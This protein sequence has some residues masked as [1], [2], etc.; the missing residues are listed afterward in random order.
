MDDST[1]EFH[2][3][4]ETQNTVERYVLDQLSEDEQ[5]RFE[6]HYAECGQCLD[7]VEAAQDLRAGLK[8]LA[9]GF[10]ADA[11][12][13]SATPSP[14]PETLDFPAPGT[15]RATTPRRWW[16]LAAAALFAL[17]T[18]PGLY[19]AQR[20][21]SLQERLAAVERPFALEPSARL[22][23]QRGGGDLAGGRETDV[24]FDPAASWLT[25]ELDLGDVNER[26][27]E[28][29]LIRESDGAVLESA[30]D[31]QVSARGI[32]VLALP[33]SQLGPGPHRL[34]V[35]ITHGDRVEPLARFALRLTER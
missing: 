14:S 20:A 16:G 18:L 9:P 29:L 35:N 23:V 30:T 17:A 11:S 5:R 24:I 10:E 3:E 6:D 1:D 22:E 2:A 19:F 27:L 8:K 12:S 25:L 15:R 13:V 26:S 31:L 28:A 21:N 33:T 34:E 7:A 32:L 4:I